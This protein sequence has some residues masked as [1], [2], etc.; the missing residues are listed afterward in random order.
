M[1]LSRLGFVPLTLAVLTAV[2]PG[3]G[4]G[5]SDRPATFVAIPDAFPEIEA[6]AVLVREPGVDL[7]LLK[8][9]E[10][11]VDALAMALLLLA[12]VRED[13]PVTATGQ[14]VPITGFVV[15]HPPRGTRRQRLERMLDRLTEAPRV[16]LGSVGWGRRVRVR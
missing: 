16:D 7:V 10:A 1:R 6:R 15:T 8:S 9:D 14:M 3:D 2:L 4:H 5:Q 12:D 13:H 11:S